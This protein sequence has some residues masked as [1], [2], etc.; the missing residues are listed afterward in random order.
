MAGEYTINS[1]KGF[2]PEKEA[3]PRSGPDELV[4]GGGKTF[5]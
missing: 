4:S 5:L 1:V 2:G 3:S